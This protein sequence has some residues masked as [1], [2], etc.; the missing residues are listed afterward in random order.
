MDA[1][2]TSVCWTADLAKS[3]ILYLQ[4]VEIR[5]FIFQFM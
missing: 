4:I 2:L 5:D 1:E 3:G